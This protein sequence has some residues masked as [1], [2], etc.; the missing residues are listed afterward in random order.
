MSYLWDLSHIQPQTASVLDGDTIPAMFWN[1][2]R[3]RGP[4]VWMRQKDFGIWRTWTW[5][6]TATAVREIAHGLM[7]LGFQ[8]REPVPLSWSGGAFSAGDALMRPFAAALHAASRGIVPGNVL[9]TDSG[10]GWRRHIL[11]FHVC[12]HHE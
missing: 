10:V 6:Q 7:A 9:Q 5:D 4:N 8:P 12:R 11:R 1:A 2:V 3:A